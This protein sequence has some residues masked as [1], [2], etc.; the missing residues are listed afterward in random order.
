MKQII[1]R[2]LIALSFIIFFIEFCIIC[3]PLGVTMFTAPFI[4]IV[5]GGDFHDVMT[6]YGMWLAL[7]LMDFQLSIVDKIEAL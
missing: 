6:K 7:K 1:K 5:I 4:W 2:L 3:L